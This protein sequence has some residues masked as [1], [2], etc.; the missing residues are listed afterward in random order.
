MGREKEALRI[1]H[2][3]GGYVGVFKS[4]KDRE[5]LSNFR[6]FEGF[7]YAPI[8]RDDGIWKDNEGV[9]VTNI[10]W[11]KATALQDQDFAAYVWQTRKYY[12]VNCDSTG[13]FYC[14]LHCHLQS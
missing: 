3:V 4:E 1:F 7:L 13:C 11:G 10:P 2:V 9:L 12:K 14:Q 8:F 5:Q 6:C